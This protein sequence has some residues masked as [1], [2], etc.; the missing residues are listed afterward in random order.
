MST[1]IKII[2]T[3]AL[4]VISFLVNTLLNRLLRRFVKKYSVKRG[5]KLVIQKIKTAVI[6]V[7]AALIIVYIWGLEV[8]NIWIFVTGLLGLV[9]IGFFAVWSIL[10]NVFAGVV[11]FFTQPF[12][13]DDRIRVLP[14]EITGTV[15]D[16]TLF[17]VKIKTDPGGL[18]SI[19]SNLI[20]Q[21]MIERLPAKEPVPEPQT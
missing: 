6:F 12:K 8:E 4:L 13:I 17:F 16:I 10:S 7:F 19:P 15:T 21:R 3:A 5:R 14:D 20:F 18:V 11:I 1:T 2:I 9:A